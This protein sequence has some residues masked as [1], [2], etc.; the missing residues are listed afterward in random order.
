MRNEYGRF[1]KNN[2]ISL[3]NKGN[4]KGETKKV[5]SML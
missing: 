2:K 4:T 1:A 3:G 5:T